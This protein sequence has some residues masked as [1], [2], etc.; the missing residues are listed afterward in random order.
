[1]SEAT[2]TIAAVPCSTAGAPEREVA[3]RCP[4]AATVVVLM[5][6]MSPHDAGEL[7]AAGWAIAE[8][9]LKGCHC[10]EALRERYG[11]AGTIIYGHHRLARAWP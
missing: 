9:G 5:P 6:G 2:L 11:L 8:H 10:A 4:H 7:V 1:M 3:V